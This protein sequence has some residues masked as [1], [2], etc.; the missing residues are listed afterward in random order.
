MMQCMR[1]ENLRPGAFAGSLICSK[2]NTQIARNRL[3]KERPCKAKERTTP[4]VVSGQVL[5]VPPGWD[6]PVN[7]TTEEAKVM[8]S[9]DEC[10]AGFETPEE[11]RQH[12]KIAHQY[13]CKFCGK[14]YRTNRSRAT[15]EARCKKNPEVIKKK[16]K[17]QATKLAFEDNCDVA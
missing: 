16:A 14:G 17:K 8:I 4:L 9:C 6:K 11:Y 13:V 3:D 5:W 10:G 1:C 12:M 2:T 7:I 15:H